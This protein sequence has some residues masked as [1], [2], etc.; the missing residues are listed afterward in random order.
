MLGGPHPSLL[1]LSPCSQGSICLPFCLPLLMTH[2]FSPSLSAPHT[3]LAVAV[4]YPAHA[5]VGASNLSDI[6]A[7]QR[8]FVLGCHKK[9]RRS[10]ESF[11]QVDR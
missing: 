5:S 7:M 6:K 11:E 2:A 1:S 10:R 8:E 9:K 4:K 3:A